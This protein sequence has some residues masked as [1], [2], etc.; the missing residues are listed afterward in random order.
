MRLRPRKSWGLLDPLRLQQVPLFVLRQDLETR[1]D[2]EP[3]HRN[4]RV[5]ESDSVHIVIARAL[6]EITYIALG[7]QETIE[8]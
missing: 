3:D 5:P 8:N 1:S 4:E 6:D 7:A 2:R